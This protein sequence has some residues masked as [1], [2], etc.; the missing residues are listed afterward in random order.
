MARVPDQ[1]QR[2]APAHVLTTLHMDL[3]HQRAGG[4]EHVETALLRVAFDALRYTVGTE[5]GNCALRHFIEFLDEARAFTAKVI[6]HVP[7]VDDFMTH[8]NRCA[9][10]LQ[11]AIDNFDRPHD[12]RAKAA[13]LGKDDSHRLANSD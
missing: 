9:M 3:R 8:V 2:A 6:D 11:S 1:D 12:S 10:L 7:V 13:G 5:N 4:I